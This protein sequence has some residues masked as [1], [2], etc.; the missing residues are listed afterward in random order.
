MWNAPVKLFSFFLIFL[1]SER[2]I[3]CKPFV[4]GNHDAHQLHNY[5]IIRSS[6]IHDHCPRPKP[7]PVGV[8]SIVKM[9][10]N[11]NYL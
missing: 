11:L 6:E 5:G 3:T 8:K 7:G 10:S 4:G 9:L 1:T 2:K